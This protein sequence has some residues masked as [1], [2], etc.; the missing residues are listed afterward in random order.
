MKS[1]RIALG[2]ALAGLA[3]AGC[4]PVQAGAAVIVG[5]QRVSMNELTDKVTEFEAAAAKAA[6]Q[7]QVP[8]VK[9][10][11]L[12]QLAQMSQFSQVLKKAGVSVTPGE[13][14]AFIGAQG[15]PQQ[16]EQVLLQRVVPPSENRRFVEISLGANKLL[17]KYGGGTDEAALQKGQ[18]QVAK[19]L[20]AVKITF[21][22]RF[23]TLDPQRGFVDAG[24]FSV[25]PQ[26]KS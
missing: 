18:A 20:E 12:L 21:N 8:S 25:A 22:P 4:A 26:P 6:Q 3:V 14:D 10:G 11:V 1:M 23:G 13:I 19:D 5:D 17:A 24:R 7:P 9:D 15:G 2:A 16:V